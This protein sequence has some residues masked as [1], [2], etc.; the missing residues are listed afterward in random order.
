MTNYRSYAL[1]AGDVKIHPCVRGLSHG[2]D[3]KG[4]ATYTFRYQHVIVTSTGKCKVCGESVAEMLE[5]GA[6][7]TKSEDQSKANNSEKGLDKKPG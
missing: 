2:K 6:T 5:M 3:T 1:G 7:I 4:W